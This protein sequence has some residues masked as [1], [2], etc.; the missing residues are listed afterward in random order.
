MKRVIEQFALRNSDHRS[1]SA[2]NVRSIPTDDAKDSS[3]YVN[4]R[5]ILRLHRRVA[6]GFS[7]FGIVIAVVY[8]VMFWSNYT[9]ESL[10]YIQPNP[11]ATSESGGGT[12]W[13]YDYDPAVYDS[14]V[15][16]QVVSI[17]SPDVLIGALHK[18]GPGVWRRNGETDASAA[19]R[20]KAAVDVARIGTSFQVSIIAH[21]SDP[22]TA[23]DLANAVAAS[24]IEGPLHDGEQN[25]NSAGDTPG[26][27]HLA[28]AAVAPRLPDDFGVVRTALFLLFSFIL[29]GV[30][31]AAFAHMLDPRIYVAA[32]ME[33]VLG[34]AP[35]AVLPDFAEVSDEV[36]GECLFMLV[37]AI[38]FAYRNGSTKRCVFVGTNRGAGVTVLASRVRKA[39]EARGLIEG[40]ARMADFGKGVNAENLSEVND[41]S[42]AL[43][44]RVVEE[45][46]GQREGLVLSEGTLLTDPA[47]ENLVRTADC[48]IVVAKSGVT[49]RTQLAETVR[50]LQ[51][52]NPPAV[53]FVLNRVSRAKADP[54]FRRLIGEMERHPYYKARNE[55]QSRFVDMRVAATPTWDNAEDDYKAAQEAADRV[56][57]S[58]TAEA[59]AAAQRREQGDKEQL[60]PTSSAPNPNEEGARAKAALAPERT[61][62]QPGEIPW[63]LAEKPM[64]PGSATR[65][66]ET[67]EAG[68]GKAAES[69]TESEQ[70]AQE[71]AK[72]PEE[73]DTRFRLPR[74][75]GL[76]GGLFSPAIRELDLAKH[77]EEHSADA[78]ALLRQI[79]PFEALFDNGELGKGGSSEAQGQTEQEQ[80]TR[81]LANADLETKTAKTATNGTEGSEAGRS[82]TGKNGAGANSY[83]AQSNESEAPLDSLTTSAPKVGRPAKNQTG[84]NGTERIDDVQIL[85]SK[86]GQYRRRG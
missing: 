52:L 71:T 15:Q 76:R 59:E 72:R 57:A 11:S 50:G 45:V 8:L 60:R 55:T 38:E 23:A 69:R 20:I 73:A 46:D 30:L 77:S 36:A 32:D 56:I 44:Q 64:R 40:G 85:P 17:T 83:N 54:G 21:A 18:L 22:E 42:M 2:S 16:Q 9:A 39:L 5:R 4:F 28:A 86:R 67:S 25:P 12:Q 61:I 41:Q 62:P 6:L 47:T 3:L 34:H 79:A 35:A 70:I 1:D 27:A 7:L 82:E 74:L 13:P 29:L 19:E 10:L 81:G 53:E 78:E 66:Q 14:Y 84:G 58:M 33:H 37:S 51:R 49:T 43:L 48:T 80:A 65:Q 31:A 63:W 68:N 24:Y 75:S 26:T